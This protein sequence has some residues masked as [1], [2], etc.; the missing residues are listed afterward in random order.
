MEDAIAAI[1][2]AEARA[3][4]DRALEQVD[5][6]SHCLPWGNHHRLEPMYYE[7]HRAR[8]MGAR[9]RPEPGRAPGPDSWDE[10]GRDREG[11]II[12]VRTLRSMPPSETFD[13]WL[14]REQSVVFAVTLG[15][16]VE[17]RRFAWDG[18]LMQAASELRRIPAQHGQP[19]F[20]Y[21][22]AE[23][24]HYVDGSLD[25]IRSA[26]FP[27]HPPG[28]WE[29]YCTIERKPKRRPV[30][31]W[32]PAAAADPARLSEQQLDAEIE[33]LTAGLAD[34]IPRLARGAGIDR[35]VYFVNL[36]SGRTH[37][38]VQVSP[39]TIGDRARIL[40][41]RPY[42]PL[43]I[44]V[45]FDQG[46]CNCDIDDD[47]GLGS[48]VQ[49]G[50]D[51]ELELQRRRD[52]IRQRAIWKDLTSRLNE[53]DWSDCFPVTDDF[54]VIAT[55]TSQSPKERANEI[56]EMLGKQRFA[57]LLETETARA[58]QLAAEDPGPPAV[59]LNQAT[60]KL[61]TELAQA[62]VMLPLRAGSQVHVRDVWDA[63]V[64]FLDTPIA[65]LDPLQGEDMVLVEHGRDA[66]RDSTFYLNLARQVDRGDRGM[67]TI[68]VE[69]R[70][71]LIGAITD[72][73]DGNRWFNPADLDEIRTEGP[74][75]PG[76]AALISADARPTSIDISR[77]GI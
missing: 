39:A 51:V 9:P 33:R 42:R 27:A 74:E 2:V 1:P 13:V 40:R 59:K 43:D 30:C 60:R 71:P 66:Y 61:K 69:L 41:R 49:L 6:W 31:V 29:H 64:A 5:E 53:R 28:P 44:Y 77:E 19:E 34:A 12:V 37:F 36:F 38:Q 7:R 23:T 63:F 50:H 3:A 20:R 11:R 15:E 75:T 54:L 47:W 25:A 18:E 70:F 46:G 10:Y 8:S 72:I 16:I 76:L 22:R 67:E 21:Y 14:S 32:R 35:P 17:L 68:R 4:V 52:D 26:D 73:Q 55:P 45:Q 57:R 24:F 65:G 48:L 62:G 58:E 56:A